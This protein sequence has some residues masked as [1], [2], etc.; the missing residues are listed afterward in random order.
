MVYR[1]HRLQP[2]QLLA[3]QGQVIWLV[4]RRGMI[5]L[6][7]GLSIG[8]LGASGVGRVLEGLLVQ[9]SPT[10]PVT[11]AMILAVLGSVSL[12]ACLGPARRAASLDPSDA[13]RV[14]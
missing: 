11:V 3:I 14:D 2:A 7:V 8:P 5:Q 10:D 4:M 6:V 13:L 1:R 12:L 9:V